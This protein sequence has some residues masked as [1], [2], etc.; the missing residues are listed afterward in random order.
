MGLPNLLSFYWAT[1]FR[2]LNY[3]VTTEAPQLLLKLEAN[4]VFLVSL[5]ALLHTTLPCSISKYTNNV[6]VAAS[7]KIWN[8]FRCHFGI[9]T[10]SIGAPLAANP[11]LPPS[12]LDNTFCLWAR[13]GIKTFISFVDSVFA[14]FQQLINTFSLPKKHFFRYLQV[15]SFT[16]NSFPQFPALP[17]ESDSEI[18]LKRVNGGVFSINLNV[19]NLGQGSTTP[20]KAV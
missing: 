16:R 1:N 7:I 19:C 18:F 8:Q 12:L 11:V 2:N 14:S 17:M 10:L 3:W 9:Q 13:L 15:R 20:L 5:N 4:S 6:V